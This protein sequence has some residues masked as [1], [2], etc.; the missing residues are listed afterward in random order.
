MD[1][2]TLERKLAL[3]PDDIVTL[4]NLSQTYIRQRRI[5]EARALLTRA[6]ALQPETLL[7]YPVNT[8]YERIMLS[9]A[10]AKLIAGLSVC[11]WQIGDFAIAHTYAKLVCQQYPTNFGL[12]SLA[13][14]DY[15]TGW[16]YWDHNT[17]STAG[18]PWWK[19]EDDRHVLVIDE[20]YGYGDTIMMARFLPILAQRC[21]VSFR[22]R[23]PLRR[24]MQIS[25]PMIEMIEEVQGDCQVR[26][27]SLPRILDVRPE[28]IP[29]EPYL[30]ADPDDCR[31]LAAVGRG[32]VGL[33]WTGSTVHQM[34][35]LR[36]IRDPTVLLPLMDAVDFVS[37][38]NPSPMPGML[39]FTPVDFADT[40]ALLTTLDLV[41]SVDTAVLN[42]AGALG[43][44][45]WLLN[46]Y[47]GD[48]RWGTEGD[49]S[50]WYPTVR[51]F[52]QP[53]FGEW[54]AVI[55]QVRNAL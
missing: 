36:S 44:P 8:E 23:S 12:I 3:D 54:A 17:T 32:K 42:L 38:G 41:I 40:A 28:T 9:A 25:L 10:I 20:D 26:L 29:R 39:E 37:I 43:V 47:P 46:Y 27:C 31:R 53:A 22:T 50:P 52:R 7:N 13:M 35:H 11:H 51:I 4:V 5:D 48:W 55:E 19:G 24:L 16:R 30:R 34:D 33:C 1:I 21:R 2:D 18:L 49:Y 45:A 6:A 15:D 14:G